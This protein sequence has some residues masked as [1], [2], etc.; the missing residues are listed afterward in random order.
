[1]FTQRGGTGHLAPS[2]A[3]A[4][5]ELLILYSNVT[6]SDLP[7]QNKSVTFEIHDALANVRATLGNYT[8]AS[9]VATA[10]FRLPA[11]G[12]PG[13][14]D[15]SV[16]GN[17]TVVSTADLDGNVV[18]DAVTFECGWLVKVVSVEPGTHVNGDWYSKT[19]FHKLEPLEVIVTLTS[20]CFSSRNVYLS[21]DYFDGQ[22]YPFF[23]SGLQYIKMGRTAENVTVRLERI[24]TWTRVGNARLQA[25]VTS[26]PVEEGGTPLCPS[27]SN[28]TL[29][30]SLHWWNYSW[31]HRKKIVVCENSGYA[32]TM[33]PIEVTFEHGGDAQPD[34]SDIRVLAETLEIPRTVKA[35]NGTHATVE[36]RINLLASEARTVFI[37]YGNRNSSS[38]G[39]L[40]DSSKEPEVL[41]TLSSGPTIVVIPDTIA[42]PDDFSS[43]QQAI[44]H[45]N[46]ADTVFAG[47]GTYH[48]TVL[49]NNSVKYL[50]DYFGIS[51]CLF[52]YLFIIAID[53]KH[54]I[55][56]F[57]LFD[58]K[59]MRVF[60]KRKTLVGSG[61]FGEVIKPYT[62]VCKFHHPRIFGNYCR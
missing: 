54:F 37:Y 40:L 39:F 48:Q 28:S 56:Q 32:Q 26:K 34:G 15:P 44:N 20:I 35:I 21:V 12:L 10:S 24:P 11:S 62:K 31:D 17:W 3:F 4:P 30:S 29:I 53:I 59:P 41:T 25:L 50:A 33:L 42:V 9:G 43:L 23:D 7:V 36:F 60:G 27:V 19:V 49:L 38:L 55:F 52:L 1:V 61:N 18:S 5:E 51:Q 57:F 45:A 6:Y 14:E 13:V 16:F 47:R 8:N 58:F 22:G 46:A 2:D